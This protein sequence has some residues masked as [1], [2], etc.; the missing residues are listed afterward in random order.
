MGEGVSSQMTNAQRPGDRLLRFSGRSTRTHESPPV[1][2]PMC[3][4]FEENEEVPETVPLDFM[5]DYVT[6][7]TSNISSVVG[8]LGAEPIELINWILC[9]VCVLEELGVFIARL[10][11]WIVNSFPPMCLVSQTNGLSPCAV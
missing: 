7:A 3:A 1:E 6:W 11:D 8:A 2:N 4:A 5:E 9:F 10:D